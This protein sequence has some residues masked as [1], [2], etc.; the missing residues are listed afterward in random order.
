MSVGDSVAGG[1]REPLKTESP[2]QSMMSK[3]KEIRMQL[4]QLQTKATLLSSSSQSSTLMDEEEAKSDQGKEIGQIKAS[5]ESLPEGPM[6]EEV[7]RGLQERL[8][9]LRREASKTRRIGTQI[10][11]CQAAIERAQKRKKEAE[12][13][14]TLTELVREEAAQE[15]ERLMGEMH[16]LQSRMPNEAGHQ[17]GGE[18]PESSLVTMNE[19]LAK[20]L[21][22]MRASQNVDAAVV[23]E[24]E[25]LMA[26]LSLGIERVAALA[27]Q[28]VA[29]SGFVNNQQAL[30]R[31]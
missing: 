9:C 31:V 20:V 10:D 2:Q 24:T 7:R 23:S 14:L 26:Q 22:E 4:E 30:S 3:G 13:L 29:N 1:W 12:E 15:E 8:Q 25:G 5:L 16:A 21:V 18:Q 17:T 28:A 11:E 27:Q 19:A 6:Y